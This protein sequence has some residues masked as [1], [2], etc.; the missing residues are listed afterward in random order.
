M[1]VTTSRLNLGW[2]LSLMQRSRMG[3]TSQPTQNQRSS[4]TISRY[5]FPIPRDRS[6]GRKLYSP[7]YQS[8]LQTT[9]TGATGQYV[10]GSTTTR[11]STTDPHLPQIPK[12]EWNPHAHSA[13]HNATSSNQSALNPLC[14]SIASLTEKKKPAPVPITTN[15]KPLS[16]DNPNSDL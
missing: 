3:A 7:S 12:P 4:S 13:N 1:S 8:W 6:R 9:S 5:T 2:R 11:K 15:H 14:P 10:F 16:Q